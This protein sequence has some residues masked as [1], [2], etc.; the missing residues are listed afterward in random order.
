MDAL[1]PVALVHRYAVIWPAYWVTASILFCVGVGTLLCGFIR[2]G[3]EFSPWAP[4]VLF[5]VAAATL[6]NPWPLKTAPP[7]LPPVAQIVAAAALAVHVVLRRREQSAASE[8]IASG[9]GAARFDTVPTRSYRLYVVVAVVLAALILFADLGGFSGLPL[10]W[11]S[12]VIGG[13]A[14]AADSGQ[15]VLA[16]A[17]HSFLWDNGILSAGH[18]S[19]FYGVPTYALFQVAGYSIWTLRLLAVVATLLSIGVVAVLG[20]RFFGT[21]TGA[22]AA[23]LLGLNTAV[24]FYGRYGSSPAGTL[25]ALLLAILA[26]WYFLDTTRP[27]WW[28]GFAC[29]AALY[30]A[31]LQ[32]S[33][34]RIV[35]V[36]LLILIAV[37]V[38]AQWRVLRW[39][40]ALGTI[41]IAAAAVGVWQLQKAYQVSQ[42]FFFARGEQYLG[43]IH[44]RDY[45]REYLGR[46]IEPDAVTPVDAIE[47]L[48]RLLQTTVPQYLALVLPHVGHTV[49]GAVITYDPPPLELYY[50]P[51]V[52]FILWGI[53]DSIARLPEWRPAFLLAWFVLGSVPLLLTNRVD[54]HR[55]FLFVIPLTLWGAWGVHE[56]ARVLREAR[57]PVVIQHVVAVALIATLAYYDI[58]VLNYVTKPVMSVGPVLAEAVAAVPGPVLVGSTW[59]H[60]EVGWARLGMLERNRRQPERFARLMDP[61]LLHGIVDDSDGPAEYH[62][63]TLKELLPT[64]TIL[65][66]PAERFQHTTAALQQRGARA[67]ELD[68]GRLRLLR[69][70]GGEKVTGI[71]DTALSP[72]PTVIIPPTPTPIPLDEG[73]QVPVTDLQPLKIEYGFAPP[74]IDRA[75]GGGPLLLGGRRYARGIGTHAW[76]RMTYAVPPGAVAFQAVIGLADDVKECPAAMV[77]FELR[78]QDDRVLYKSDRIDTTSSPVAVRVDLGATRELSLVVTEG[79]NGR[80]CDHADWAR[81]AFLLSRP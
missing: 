55:A 24:L 71:P 38:V 2:R 39:S 80:D 62:L 79:G 8:P 40:R 66:A 22:A 61:G 59:D 51:A 28:S 33:P 19:L 34:A 56:A 57:V 6:F 54:A 45:L 74:E 73:P 15:S 50:V 53:F 26:T 43:F 69:F 81:P 20:R 37:V 46:V 30:A 27:P 10:T 18:T 31:T 77:T 23:V 58:N 68:R 12:A 44:H 67:A 36:L 65:L 60:R 5:I 41:V 3:R 32:Y 35:V 52:L 78:D 11:E 49:P 48:Y 13:F 75:F 7:W 42:L 25:L 63:R 21:V 14:E 16:Y 9:D 72:L 64:T 70:D 47:L 76:C 1:V 4:G 17:L 29:A